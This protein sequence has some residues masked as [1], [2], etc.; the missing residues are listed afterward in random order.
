[1]NPTDAPQGQSWPDR[2]SSDADEADREVVRA[3]DEQAGETVSSEMIPDSETV[4]GAV[5]F[6]SAPTTDAAGSGLVVDAPSAEVAAAGP[7]DVVEVDVVEADVVQSDEVDE[8]DPNLFGDPD[9]LTAAVEAILF[10]VES[11]ISLTAIAA[12]LQ[13]PT[14][15]IEGA[16]ARLQET[17]DDPARGIE[18][19]WVADGVRIYTRSELSSVVEAFLLDGQR[20]KLSQAALETLAVIAYR[21]PVARGRISAIRGVN[22]DGVVRTLT[23][24]GLIVED[25]ADPDSGAGLFRT[26]SLFLEKMGLQSLEELPSLAPLLPDIDTLETDEL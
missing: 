8:L 22:V 25:G 3:V 17:Y 23:G 9:R 6:E 12:V 26:T 13:Q 2:P 7:M 4:T 19:R 20:T 1:V 18:L 10:V 11:P 16:V 14:E 15:V 5:S 24:R 21:Q